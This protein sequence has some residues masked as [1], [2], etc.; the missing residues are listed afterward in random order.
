MEQVGTG[1]CG[2]VCRHLLTS[3]AIGSPCC[4]CSR[5][6]CREVRARRAG[7]SC[8]RVGAVTGWRPLLQMPFHFSGPPRGSAGDRGRLLRLESLWCLGSTVVVPARRCCVTFAI[9]RWWERVEL[10]VFE[11]LFDLLSVIT[12][13]IPETL[14]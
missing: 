4:S 3:Q 12:V 2:L 1:L 5:K 7:E 8:L 10:C 9:Q 11:V 13:V 6:H 14:M